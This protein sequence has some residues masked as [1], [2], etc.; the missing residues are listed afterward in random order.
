MC[1]STG[2]EVKALAG[3]RKILVRRLRCAGWAVNQVLPLRSQD[4][5]CSKGKGD[6]QNLIREEA[7]RV[8][9]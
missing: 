4:H 6:Q 3:Q 8:G 9:G 1:R 7:P 2:G 5:I